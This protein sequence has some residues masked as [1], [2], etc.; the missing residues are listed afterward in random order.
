VST[1]VSPTPAAPIPI[2]DSAVISDSEDDSSV[3]S[4]TSQSEGGAGGN[5]N[6]YDDDD[7]LPPPVQ[8]PEGAPPDAPNIVDGPRRSTREK[9]PVDRYVPGSYNI[10]DSSPNYV[11][12]TG[13]SGSLAKFNLW[14]F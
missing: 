11:W 1:P 5:N 9:K 4:G 10:R 6:F 8:A 7:S 14:A 3:E 12:K 13:A 2:G